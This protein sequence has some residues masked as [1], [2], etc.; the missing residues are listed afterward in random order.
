MAKTLDSRDSLFNIEQ[1][2]IIDKVTENISL[3]NIPEPWFTSTVLPAKQTWETAWETYNLNPAERTKSMT[4]AKNSARKIYEAMLRQLCTLLVGNPNVTDADL[5]M[6]GIVGRRQG[7]HYP[8]VPVPSD[9]PDFR[10]EQ[11][12]GHRL[13]LYFHTHEQQK[14]SSAAKPYGVHGAEIAYAILETHPTSYNDLTKSSF[15]TA[16]PYVFTFDLSDA[17]KT[18]YVAVRWENSRGEKGPWSDIQAAII[19]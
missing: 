10:V 3:W 13:I 8:H 15:D 4:F 6:M 5:E 1:R 11:A 18:I 9:V 14:E 2:V 7:K 19:P 12:P 16:S 17:G